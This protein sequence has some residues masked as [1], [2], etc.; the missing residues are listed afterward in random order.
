[1][2]VVAKVMLLNSYSIGA[3]CL[4]GCL[5]SLMSLLTW[6]RTS[7]FFSYATCV[8]VGNYD[9]RYLHIKKTLMSIISLGAFRCFRSSFPSLD[10]CTQGILPVYLDVAY[11]SLYWL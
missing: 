10:R 11:I 8:P 1:M 9:E 6:H 3:S 7:S 4:G 2:T 5:C